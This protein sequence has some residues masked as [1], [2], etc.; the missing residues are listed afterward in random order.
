MNPALWAAKTGLDAQQTRMAVMSNNLANVNTTG[1]KKA[2]R[3]SRTCS[4][5][6][7]R[8]VG[9][10]DVAGHAGA[11]RACPSAPACASSRPR[12]C[13][14]RAISRRPATRSTS[15]SRAAAS[16]RSCCRTAPRPTRATASFQ[17]NADGELVTSSG[18]TRA[19]GITI[20]DGRAV[21]SR[22]A[23]TASSRVQLPGSPTPTQIGTLQLVDFV[24][25]AGLQPRGENLLRRD[26]PSSGPAADRHAR[27]RTA[28]ARCCR[29]R[30]RASNVNVVEELV[31]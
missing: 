15:R 4:I 12:S 8:Q 27:P 2:A 26:R 31:T 19:A 1:F 28:S 17:L 6:T 5:R 24:N 3:C 9:A 25:P 22:S 30:S 21:A 23:S 7:S 10:L 13:T 18:Y 14:R 29:A 20:P 11:D 16:S